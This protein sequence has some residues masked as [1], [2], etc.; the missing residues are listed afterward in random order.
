[1][2]EQAVMEHSGTQAAERTRTDIRTRAVTDRRDPWDVRE[3]RPAFRELRPETDDR[4]VG[5]R[6][7]RARTDP[8]M[9]EQR[10]V[11][12]AP[13]LI[14]ETGRRRHA[15]RRAHSRKEPEVEVLAEGHPFGGV[16]ERGR[17]R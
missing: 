8:K 12:G 3:C 10:I 11:P 2:S 4:L 15:V 6:R 5:D 1:M 17:I 7:E 14:V 13:A 9:R 16:R